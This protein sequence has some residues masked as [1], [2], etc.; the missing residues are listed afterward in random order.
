MVRRATRLLPAPLAALFLFG[1]GSRLH[2]QTTCTTTD[3]AVAAIG[4]SDPAALAGDCTI[5]L[6]AKAGWG[7]SSTTL[8]WAS[9]LSMSSWDGVAVR[10]SRVVRLDFRFKSL[11]GSIPDLSG[12]A[13]LERLDLSW[14]GLTGNIPATLGSLTKLTAL[15]LHGNQLTGSIPDL[16][17]LANLE[18]LDLGSNGLT[19]NIP[20]TLGSLTKLKWLSLTTNQLDGSAPALGA[21]VNLEDLILSKNQLSGSIP[22]LSSLAS[23]EQLDLAGNRLTGSIPATLGSLA[24]LEQLTLWNNQLSG[25]IPDLSGLSNLV[26]LHLHQNRLT[27]SIPASLGSLA[28]LL[29]LQL[30]KNQLT[31]SIPKELGSLAK[32]RQLFLNENR[33]T[34]N[35]PAELGSLVNVTN[36][37]LHK[38]QLT[39]PIPDLSALTSLWLLSLEDNQLTGRIPDLDD[40][41]SLAY[42]SL[43]DNQLTGTIPALPASVQSL[44]LQRNQVSG[45]IPDLSALTGLHTLYLH[46]NELTGT[47]PAT[48]GDLTSLGQLHLAANRLTGGIPGD[49][50][51]LTSLW[52]LSLCGNDLDAAATLPT[53]LEAR[54]TAS[55]LDVWPCVWIDDATAVEGQ[56]LAFTVT[57]STQPVRGATGAASLRLTWWTIDGTAKTPGDYTRRSGLITIPGNTDSSTYLS[58]ATVSVPTVVDAVAEGAETFIVRIN[59]S[60]A[61]FVDP[62]AATGTITEPIPDP[63]VDISVNNGGSLTEGGTVTITATVSRAPSGSSLAVPLQRVAGHSAAA[64]TDYSLS[65]SPAGTITVADGA[66]TGTLTLTAASD[67]IDETDETLRLTLGAVAGYD[68]GSNSH[69][70]V[71]ITDNT[72]TSV[73]LSLPDAAA[74]EGNAANTATIRLTLGRGLVDGEVLAVPLQFTGGTAGTDF[75]LALSAAA[76][77]V[78]FNSAN[79]TVTFTGPQT[80]ATATA[81][82]IVLTPADDDDAD[83]RTVTVSIPATSTGAGTILTA[84]N[85]DG[86]ATGSRTGNG[87]IAITDDETKSLAFS[88][89]TVGVTEEASATYTVQLGS[90]PTG[91]VTVTITGHGGTD[92]TVDTDS[93][94]PGDQ[95]TLS[96]TTSDWNTAQTVTVTASPDDDLDNEAAITLVHSASGGGYDAVSGNVTVNITDNDEPTIDVTISS[97]GTVRTDGKLE[98]TEGGTVTIEATLSRAP[99]GG[100]LSIPLQHDGDNSTAAAADYSLSGSPA[101]T[102]TIADGATSGSLALTAA[103]DSIDEQDETLRLALGAVAGYEPGSASHVDV[104]ITDNTATSVTLSLPDAAAEEGN[105]ANTATIRLTLGR[106]LVD[107]EVLAVPLQFTGGTAG[108]DFT[109]ALSAAAAGVAFN[110]ANSTVTFTGPQT[111]ATATAADIVLTPADDDD[112]DDR[113]V[114]VSIPATST[115][116]GTILTATNL[117]GGAT[118]SRTGNG[119]IAIADDD[120]KALVLLPTTSVTVVEEATE[121]YTVNL[122]TRP[123][124]DVTVAI[125]GYG[126]TDLTLD[127]ASLTFRATTWNVPQTV[128]VTANPDTNTA[129]ESIPP[130]HTA[131][132]G[133]YASIA[134]TLTVNVTDNDTAGLV[135]STMVP[136]DE[137]RSA[138]Y[139]VKLATEPSATVTVVVSGFENSD[140][141]LD[142]TALTFTTANWNEE[143][144]VTVTADEDTDLADDTVDLD[145]VAD[146][147][148]YAGVTRSI[149]VNIKDDDEA[150]ATFEL[151]GASIDEAGG[152]RNVMV[153]LDPTPIK[154]T[155]LSYTLSGAPVHG[156]DYTI[157]GANSNS[158]T[159]SVPA[160][161][162]SVDITVE[163]MDDAVVEDA[164]TIVLTLADGP[165]YTPGTPRVHRLIIMDND[166][167]EPPPPPPPPPEPPPTVEPP[168]PTPTPPSGPVGPAG[169]LVASF[170][171]SGAECT[172]DLCTTFTGAPVTFTDTSTGAVA[173]RKWDTGD[174]ETSRRPILNHSWAEPGFYR[175]ALT[176]RGDGEEDQAEADFLVRPSQP[177]GTCAPDPWTLCLLNER[178][179]VQVDWRTRS[180][181]TGRGFALYQG[182]NDSGLFWFFDRDNWEV[183][184]KVLDGCA[185][186]GR[187]WVFS[188]A[189]TDVRYEMTV[190]DTLGASPPKVYINE[191][192][193]PAVA[194]TD[195]SAFPNGCER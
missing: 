57:Y 171:I 90:R 47:I 194:L 3:T 159:A 60:A 1:V 49:L 91:I 185:V 26:S 152:S 153:R 174:G 184:V 133:G 23:L 115:G 50:G 21:L 59:S 32:L 8:N 97:G 16:S 56:P 40:L 7:G 161:A 108:T 154:S 181:D 66:T 35:I 118:G 126:Q 75:T 83:D 151:A 98:V 102:I 20:A 158:G 5:L 175:V 114:T 19:G 119:Q 88:S 4:A 6:G 77:G 100:T 34:G 187:H 173:E 74:E 157:S 85:L 142:E 45:S 48:L 123:R 62:D 103:S 155:M 107:G 117:D 132:G 28:E 135:I 71:T 188:A 37:Q 139:T 111:G 162:A 146:G 52:G 29:N 189:T 2:A 22:D 183:L 96:F 164:E 191:L 42:L 93:G 148:D 121:T 116:A 68:H 61:V 193:R 110:S 120:R 14:N 67:S 11:S 69:V 145:H 131:S 195:T 140:L 46:Q 17:G 72:A 55:E 156:D 178:Y 10:D 12:L 124:G 63:T 99:S 38:N 137:G 53:A 138:T 89:T 78:A 144:T 24:N 180:G 130:T 73:T 113:T 127:K 31:G 179:R 134:G 190:T 192:D 167:A 39:G 94:T 33:L 41:A 177:D 86:G 15:V 176:V 18:T 70:D 143:Q 182:T 149:T 80:G 141:T 150:V 64:T 109:L 30:H 166:E 101:G 104:T 43:E 82:D 106:G 165:G 112:A 25:S 95:D 163:V 168:P 58:T 129:N 186:D 105:A 87:E 76:A 122:A 9:T 125:T 84:T 65:G 51:K 172:E 160:G 92:L 27:G 169:P 147:G 44:S 128:T 136:V 81:A 170:A 54:R 79:S 13:N 36:L